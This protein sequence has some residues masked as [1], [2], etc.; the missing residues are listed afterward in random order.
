MAT[1]TNWLR[2][3][4]TALKEII[5]DLDRRVII[6]LL[7]IPALQTIS[8]Y[9]TSRQFF[10]ANLFHLF[11]LNAD[12]YLY[13]YLFWF[14]GDFITYFIFPVIVIKSLLRENVK[15][16]GVKFGDWRLGLKISLLFL[17][18]ML[19][20]VWF[21][22]ASSEFVSKY[23]HLL[24]LREIWSK[25][26]IY[27]IA[28]LIYM[29]AWEFIWR[30]F[31]LFGLEAKF[32]YYAVFIQMIPFVILH[33]GKPLPETLGAILGGIALGILAFRTRSFI[34]GVVVHMGI[35]FSIDFICSL[36]FRAGDYGLG[37]NSVIN[38]IGEI[39]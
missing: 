6:T 12:V 15:D 27:E 26:I 30:G 16:F 29:F 33:N 21:A 9:V 13:E 24:S 14:L 22:S 35:M 20:I 34:Y 32:G 8:W 1:E 3:E 4:L 19:P 2:K 28:M 17:T 31:L 36:R 7:S 10:R 38:L 39:F 18:L 11:Q 23:P 37:V 25:F 5:L